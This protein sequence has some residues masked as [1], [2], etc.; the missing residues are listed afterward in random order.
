MDSGSVDVNPLRHWIF[1]LSQQEQYADDFGRT[2]AYDSR[3]STRVL[4]GDYF[5]YLDKRGGGYGFTGHGTVTQVRVKAPG[6]AELSQSK[7]NSHL[8]R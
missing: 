7:Y 1:K 5:L 8:Y 4:A 2:Y 3:H 6:L